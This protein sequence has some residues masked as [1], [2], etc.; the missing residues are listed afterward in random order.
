MAETTRERLINA[1][2]ELFFQHGF[3]AVALDQIIERVG[4][5][6]TTFY[7]H[8]E[9]KDALVIAVLQERDRI[10][11][12]EW[13]TI[14]ERRGGDDPRAR[15]LAMFDLVEDWLADPA[16]TGCIFLKAEVEYPSPNDPVHQAALVHGRNLSEAL[17]VQA[18]RGGVA[19]PELVAGQLMMLLG[20]AI[21][22][23]QYTG[24]VDRAR[25]A[26]ATAEVLVD[27]HMPR[28]GTAARRTK[29]RTS[30]HE[31]AVGTPRPS[32]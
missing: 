7:N 19:D 28:R 1:A 2:S 16:F 17:R 3:H 12:D 20:G 18:Q 11:L 4:V 23:R 25:T 26:R 5:T 6:K 9:S 10:E 32:P 24:V 8:F 21:L 14:M 27:H 29:P 22:T 30:G 15:I 13:L 31:Q